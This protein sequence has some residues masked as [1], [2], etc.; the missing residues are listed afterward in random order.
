MNLTGVYNADIPKKDNNVDI[1]IGGVNANTVLMP[2]LTLM[3]FLTLDMCLI[4]S[5]CMSWPVFVLVV[6]L[7]CLSV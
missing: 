4:T 3:V 2:H 7:C 1:I 6:T 5:V